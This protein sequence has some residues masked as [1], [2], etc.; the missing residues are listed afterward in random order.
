MSKNLVVNGSFEDLD[1]ATAMSKGDWWATRSLAGWT[2]EGKQSDNTNWFEVVKSGHRNVATEYGS[3]WLDMDASPGN[4]AIVQKVAGVEADK[5]YTLFVTLASG[6]NGDGVDIFWGGV[7]LANIVP[8]GTAME[9]YS[10][11]VT[12]FD[13][14]DLNTIRIVGTGTA[15]GIGVSL[16]DVSLIRNPDPIEVDT[17]IPFVINMIHEATSNVDNYNFGAGSGRE[18][19]VNFD[20]AVDRIVIRAD[21]ATSWADLQSKA[22]IYQSQGSTVF[23]FHNGSENMVFVQTDISK[24]SASSFIFEGAPSVSSKTVG[25]NLIQ[26][27]S[28]ENIG[29][30]TKNGW[31]LGA[32]TLDG[33]FLEGTAKANSN[34]LEMHTSGQRGVAASDG[35]YWLDMDASSGNIAVSQNVKGVEEGKY[36]TLSLHAASSRAGNT[37]DIFWDGQKIGTVTPSGTGMQEYSFVVEGHAVNLN[38]LTFAGTGTADGHGV[39][40]DNVRLLAHETV[41]AKA[42][43]FTFG[44]G[45]GRMYAPDFDHARDK[46]IVRSDLFENYEEFKKNSAVYQDGASAFIEFNN[47][48]EMIVLLQFDAANI[49]ED[50]FIFEGK[51][52]TTDAR[53]KA[54]IQQGTDGEDTMIFGAG[55][56]TI[57][58][59]AGFD[60]ISGGVGADKFMFNA[61][62]GHDF[63]TDFEVGVDRIVVSRDLAESYEAMMK[64]GAIYQDGKSTHVEFGT[65]QMITLYNIDAKL[66]SADWFV[67]A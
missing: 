6:G 50:M 38:K 62:S 43:T 27:G 34:W 53:G 15:D 48:R 18:F 26:N 29:T 11:V 20:F 3:K 30:S 55:S 60:I 8:S 61:K 65:G 21:L 33:W 32:L 59:G 5:S 66:A 25:S 9:T 46:I 19:F 31:G 42:D 44:L 28:F 37:L 12:G 35:K 17:S 23:E 58:G 10:V 57:D 45:S 22:A 63:I 40:V 2:L 51:S 1:A 36:Y 14:P 49:S 67:F 4:V 41:E 16:D 54:V 47:G 24:I 39:S 64:T 13:N 52:R 56:Q 7:K